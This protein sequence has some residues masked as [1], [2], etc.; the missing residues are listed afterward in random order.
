MFHTISRDPPTGSQ[1]VHETAPH[2]KSIMIAGP[3]GT[4]KRMLVNAI[5]SELGANLIDLTAENICGRYPGKEEKKNFWLTWFTN[6]LISHILSHIWHIFNGILTLVEWGFLTKTLG[7]ENSSICNCQSNVID[8]SLGIN[9]D[10][11]EI[12]DWI[13][14]H[15][16]SED[17]FAR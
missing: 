16:K 8:W 5:C 10:E 13:S 9:C 2:V 6:I 14:T 17:W 7:M 12:V 3:H 1:T 11:H 15:L 4:G